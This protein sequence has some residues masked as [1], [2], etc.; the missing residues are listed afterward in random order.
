MRQ[1]IALSKEMS[2]KTLEEVDSIQKIPYA[3]AVGVL[4]MLCCVRDRIFVMW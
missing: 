3:S 4:C 1:G 2:L